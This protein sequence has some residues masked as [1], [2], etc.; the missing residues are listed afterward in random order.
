M[1]PQVA[2]EELCDAYAVRDFETAKECASSLLKWLRREGF[3]PQTMP[4]RKF[5]ARWNRTV[6]QAVCEMVSGLPNL[7]L[8]CDC[9]TGNVFF[10][11]SEGARKR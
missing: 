10:L 2:W 9:M 7:T 1:D 8:S 6:A 3:P 4:G 5:D 11:A